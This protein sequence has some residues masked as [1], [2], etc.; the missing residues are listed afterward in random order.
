MEQRARIKD[1]AYASF[2]SPGGGTG[3]KSVVSLLVVLVLLSSLSPLALLLLQYVA[4]YYKTE[5]SDLLI[6][7]M[8]CFV[9]I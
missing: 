7:L 3:A 2:S 5:F 1:D 8:F 9:Y 4:N 6:S